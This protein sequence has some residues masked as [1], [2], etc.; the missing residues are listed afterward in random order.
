MECTIRSRDFVGTTAADRARE[1]QQFF[2]MLYPDVDEGYMV[3]SHPHPTRLTPHGT[4][5]LVSDWFDL[6]HASW[7]TIAQAAHQR[8]QR[9][10][11]YF[12]VAIQAPSCTP[13]PW[14]RAW[15][16]SAFVIPGLWLDCDLGYGAHKASTLPSTDTE[17]LAFLDN[18]PAPPSVIIHSGGGL[19]AYWLFKEPERLTTE[20]E[21]ATMAQLSHQFTRTV[22][23]AGTERGWTLDA[24]GD[25]ARVLRPPGTIN[26]KYGKPVAVIH[27]SG[28]RYNPSDFDWLVDMPAP[29]RAT[30]AGLAIPGQPDLIAIAEHYGTTFMQKSA[31]ELAGAHPQHGSSTGDN[32]NV[33]V[34][35]GL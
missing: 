33:N 6:A 29:A 15:N 19:H 13:E 5:A 9:E 11:V 26:H 24:L 27:E 18:L 7:Q 16:S 20:A 12:N 30:H 35:K 4:A 2:E 17:A 8:A 10:T 21:R 28:L 1:I 25:L 31:T 3:L 23:Q 22:V 14:R 34:S 32:F